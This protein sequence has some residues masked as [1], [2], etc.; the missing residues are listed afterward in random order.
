MYLS[1][2]LSA[3]SL[4]FA[5]PLECAPLQMFW[6]SLLPWRNSMQQMKARAV[7]VTKRVFFLEEFGNALVSRHYVIG[8]SDDREC[9]HSEKPCVTFSKTSLP[10][11]S[12]EQ[13]IV[14][15]GRGKHQSG[16]R[17]TKCLLHA[18]KLSNAFRNCSSVLATQFPLSVS[19]CCTPSS[20]MPHQHGAAQHARHGVKAEGS[21]ELKHHRRTKPLVR[22]KLQRHPDPCLSLS[23]GCR[24]AV[25]SW[26]D[27]CRWRTTTTCCTSQTST[28]WTISDTTSSGTRVMPGSCRV[29]LSSVAEAGKAQCPD[30]GELWSRPNL[31]WTRARKF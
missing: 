28:S 7:L 18:G 22:V 9:C 1:F 17:S 4:M 19:A 24:F 20:H 16:E 13:R 29:R 6:L 8:I 23:S 2:A 15:E 14:V 10:R 5:F 30:L 26:C 3:R 12:P 11:S 31:H 25:I 27:T 21:P